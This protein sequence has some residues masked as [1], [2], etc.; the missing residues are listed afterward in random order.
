MIENMMIIKSPA[1]ELPADFSGGFVKI[2]AVN[3]PEK[4]SAII[5]YGAGFAQG[6]TFDASAIYQP[7]GTDWLGFDNGYRDLPADMPS[8]LYQYENA[9]NPQIK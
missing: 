5:S 2:T 1:P 7:G 9:T 3:L 8:H 4:N 6:A